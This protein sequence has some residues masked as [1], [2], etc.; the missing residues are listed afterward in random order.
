[1]DWGLL[2]IGLVFALMLIG[3]CELLFLGSLCGLGYQAVGWL[4]TG[5]WPSYTIAS[6]FNLPSELQLTHWVMVDRAIHYV[7]FDA[8]TA[9]VLLGIA[10]AVF[11]VKSWLDDH[12][13]RRPP[14]PAP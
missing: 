2:I 8:E 12:Q 5:K 10:I 14:A 9:V 4:Q 7:L 3:G 1:M 6:Q 11:P 13:E